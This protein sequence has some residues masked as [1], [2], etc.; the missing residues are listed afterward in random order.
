M[1]ARLA[2]KKTPWFTFSSIV[3]GLSSS[4]DRYADGLKVRS[5]CTWIGSLPRNFSLEWKRNATGV[6][7][8][9]MCFCTLASI[10]SDKSCST[11]VTYILFSG[12]KNT[13]QLYAWRD[14][15]VLGQARLQN[16]TVGKESLRS[17]DSRGA[18][19]EG[20]G[21]RE[22]TAQLPSIGL[23][24]TVLHHCSIGWVRAMHLGQVSIKPINIYSL[25]LWNP[26]SL[27]L[28]RVRGTPCSKIIVPVV[29]LLQVLTCIPQ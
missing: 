21:D 25:S 18:I 24:Q 12:C 11:I 26:V 5:T 16:L 4:V 3:Q 10:S 14:G 9:T 6:R 23:T 17:W 19:G 22:R 8:L 29:V 13:K 2:K 7:L 15:S 1:N 20:R 28:Q 27:P